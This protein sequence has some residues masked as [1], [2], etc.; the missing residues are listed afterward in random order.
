MIAE[1]VI[2][3]EAELW[4]VNT[5]QHDD[6]DFASFVDSPAKGSQA[7]ERGFAGTVLTG[8]NA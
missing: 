6:T 4:V 7:R 8:Q 3:P 5:E 1:L 2:L